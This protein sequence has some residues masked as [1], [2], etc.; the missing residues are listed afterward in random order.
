MLAS[1]TARASANSGEHTRL[2]CWFWRPAKTNF[3]ESDSVAT[4]ARLQKDCEREDALA[5]TR[6]ARAPQ[7]FGSQRNRKR[8]NYIGLCRKKSHCSSR[9]RARK[10]LE[11]DA[12]WWRTFRLRPTCVRKLM[13][14]SAGS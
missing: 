10:A 5:S 7:K 8:V 4:I 3:L 12:N 14:S 6:D 11:W 13:K 9:A 2:A 1:G